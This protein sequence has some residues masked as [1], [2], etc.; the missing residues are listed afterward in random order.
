MARR[1]LA[2]LLALAPLV[3]GSALAQG[4]IH[5]LRGGV[6]AHDI[7]IVAAG[8]YEYGIGLN[9]E[10]AFSPS[11]TL[12]GGQ[13]RP[14]LGGT[15]ATEG[16]TSLIYLDAK[17]EWMVDRLF[18][19]IGLGPAIQTGELQYVNG[20]KGLGSRVLFHVPVEVG[21][22]MTQATRVSVY[23]EHVSNAFLA[24]PNPGMDNIGLRFAYRF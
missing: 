16:G 4:F 5:E 2:L 21:F 12:F 17:W 18:F 19:G 6:L 10:I 1:L 8:R 9:A 3:P 20:R 14:A 7:P 11:V 22:Q 13:I 23:Y 24:Y 15:F